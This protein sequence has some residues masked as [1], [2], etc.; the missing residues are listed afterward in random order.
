[1]TW[2][3]P[4]EREDNTPLTLP[5]ISHFNVLN[6]TDGTVIVP[7]ITNTVTV[8]TQNFPTGNHKIVMTTVDTEGRESVFSSILTINSATS[9][10]SV[11]NFQLKRVMQ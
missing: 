5:E 10:K 7:N 4:T 11:T 6:A 8:F 2:V 3:A 9:P 1:M